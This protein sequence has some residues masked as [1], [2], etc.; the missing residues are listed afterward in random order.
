MINTLNDL[1][2]NYTCNDIPA[3]RLPVIKFPTFLLDISSGIEN[4]VETKKGISEIF[5][6]YFHSEVFRE[7]D[8]SEFGLMLLNYLNE[9]IDNIFIAETKCQKLALEIQLTK[10]NPELKQRFEDARNAKNSRA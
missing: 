3:E 1:T 5:N 4:Y 7:S 9:M 6:T 10:D 8:N 2:I